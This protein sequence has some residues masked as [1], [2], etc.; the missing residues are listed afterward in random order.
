MK[1]AT[2]YGGTRDRF[3][4]FY[5]RSTIIRPANAEKRDFSKTKIGK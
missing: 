5:K 3:D 4:K 2:W 1:P